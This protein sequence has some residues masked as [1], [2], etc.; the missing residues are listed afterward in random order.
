M[1]RRVPSGS[2]AP[3][4]EAPSTAESGKLSAKKRNEDAP[5]SGQEAGALAGS[6]PVLRAEDSAPGDGHSGG[7]G[8]QLLKRRSLR[9]SR[10]AP[11]SVCAERKD[12]GEPPRG[13]LPPAEMQPRRGRSSFIL[14]PGHTGTSAA[15]KPPAPAEP[16]RWGPGLQKVA[17]LGSGHW[18]SEVWDE[19][20]D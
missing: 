8:S 14:Y 1:M 18:W 17:R 3:D 15:H 13:A 20:R 2:T 10:V 5:Y 12:T 4:S 9:E 6:L 19:I 16:Q 11:P 7:G